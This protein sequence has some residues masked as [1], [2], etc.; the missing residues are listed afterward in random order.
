MRGDL[1]GD[2]P[3]EAVDPTRMEGNKHL[4]GVVFEV[5]GYL[6]ARVNIRSMLPAVED[7]AIEE[8]ASLPRGSRRNPALIAN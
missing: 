2:R 8:L 5:N 6:G 1:S 7:S 3:V 4:R